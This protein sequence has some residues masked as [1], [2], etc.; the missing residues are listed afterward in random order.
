MCNPAFF[1][2]KI[3]KGCSP[4]YE[5]ICIRRILVETPLLEVYLR[6]HTLFDCYHNL[7]VAATTPSDP[8]PSPILLCSCNFYMSTFISSRTRKRGYRDKDFCILGK[9]RVRTK[10]LPAPPSSP[11]VSCR[12]PIPNGQASRWR[13]GETLVKQYVVCWRGWLVLKNVMLKCIKHGVLKYR[14]NVYDRYVVQHIC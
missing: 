4:N 14:R 3:E 1:L 13:I 10:V 11:D 2:R 9:S 8:S 6:I 7:L 5:H 12:A